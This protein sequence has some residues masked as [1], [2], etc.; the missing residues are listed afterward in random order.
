[1]T[2]LDILA[3]MNLNWSP[4][5]KSL[6]KFWRQ[7]EF[8]LLPFGTIDSTDD[9]LLETKKD[10][11]ILISDRMYGMAHSLNSY[12]YRIIENGILEA[13]TN[14]IVITNGV[15]REI[16]KFIATKIEEMSYATRPSVLAVVASEGVVFPPDIQSTISEEGWVEKFSV[17]S[18]MET[19]HRRIVAV[20][21]CRKWSSRLNVLQQILR[22]PAY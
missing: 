7:M 20:Q 19:K 5:R 10:R 12:L 6:N 15:D 4:T 13:A 18:D 8:D 16:N 21:G 3:Q 14:G 1:M 9:T 2:T 22:V 11:F 17:T